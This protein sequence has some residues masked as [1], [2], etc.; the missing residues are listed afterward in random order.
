MQHWQTYFLLISDVGSFHNALSFFFIFLVFFS[1]IVYTVFIRTSFVSGKTIY[2]KIGHIDLKWHFGWRCYFSALDT[3][4]LISSTHRKMMLHIDVCNRFHYIYSNL[5]CS[6]TPFLYHPLGFLFFLQ[7]FWHPAE[8][9]IFDCEITQ[10]MPVDH[11]NKF[12]CRLILFPFCDTM[13]TT[14]YDMIS[15][16]Q[17]PFYNKNFWKQAHCRERDIEFVNGTRG[18]FPNVFHLRNASSIPKH[19]LAKII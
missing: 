17:K 12:N 1:S 14:R 19:T 5:F 7:Y 11:S 15:F 13:M 9:V 8:N 3:N 6:L 18:A 4:D 16:F 10:F 2:E